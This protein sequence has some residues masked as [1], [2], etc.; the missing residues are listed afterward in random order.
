MSHTFRLVKETRRLGG[1]ADRWTTL[2]SAEVRALAAQYPLVP[3]AELL[4][5]GDRYAL[6]LGGGSAS[7]TTCGNVLVTRAST[8][9]S[10]SLP[11][12]MVTTRAGKSRYTCAGIGA[13]DSLEAALRGILEHLA[14]QDSLKAVAA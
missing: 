3:T 10:E 6:E 2:R 14:Q 1:R 11:G 5:P 7:R 8:G 9:V 12:L 4:T 13:W